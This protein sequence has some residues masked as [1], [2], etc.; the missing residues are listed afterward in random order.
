MGRKSSLREGVSSLTTRSFIEQ[1]DVIPFK[2]EGVQR[3]TDALGIIEASGLKDEAMNV[4]EALGYTSVW[5]GMEIDKV[6]IVKSRS[7]NY[8]VID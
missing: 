2:L 5:E 3:L 1:C 6:R 8:G 7:G 4:L